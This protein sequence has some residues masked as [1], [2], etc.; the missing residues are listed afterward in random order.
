MRFYLSLCLLYLALSSC[1]PLQQQAQKTLHDLDVQATHKP[2]L[3][4]ED[5]PVAVARVNALEGM[6]DALETG[7]DEQQV[8]LLDLNATSSVPP[9]LI[10]TA[11]YRSPFRSVE[12][13]LNSFGLHTV[14]ST[15]L[16]LSTLLAY[17]KLL[18]QT[19]S[20]HNYTME[21]VQISA[22]LC[23][24]AL[25]V[26]QAL[27]NALKTGAAIFTQPKRSGAFYTACLA[28]QYPFPHRHQTTTLFAPR[29]RLVGTPASETETR[30][31]P[32]LTTSWI[33]QGL[34]LLLLLA[35]TLTA[36]HISTSHPTRSDWD[37]SARAQD[38]R[39]VL[40]ALSGVTATL[41]ALAL[42]ASATSWAARPIL[43]PPAAPLSLLW[44]SAIFSELALAALVQ[45]AAA[46]FA[47][48]PALLGMLGVCAAN[49]VVLVVIFGILAVW[50]RALYSAAI[51]RA[52]RGGGV[53]PLAV[54]FSSGLGACIFCFQIFT[55][56]L[57]AEPW[58]GGSKVRRPEGVA[59][60]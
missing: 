59:V 40:R 8:I 26:M 47:G 57:E 38:Q 41:L 15:I 53:R 44:E 43:L 1:Q 31:T 58:I 28:G 54:V 19:S 29:R 18:G 37:I 42:H 32:R 14:P 34:L 55:M 51:G 5:A 20:S 11:K 9:T 3:L 6:D 60:L 23:F 21:L 16:F 12:A 49:R 56:V 27:H 45:D 25:P 35:M 17:A 22:Y 46:A 36:F 24:P 30:R 4:N 50:N 52:R 2:T 10:L 13:L 39:S 48:A 33:L 7:T